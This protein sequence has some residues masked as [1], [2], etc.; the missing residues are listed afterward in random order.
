MSDI[1]WAPGLF[2]LTI[3]PESY[4]LDLTHRRLAD[5]VIAAHSLER[6]EVTLIEMNERD[7]V[8]S[9]ISRIHGRR[10]TKHYTIPGSTG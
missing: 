1:D 4:R 8:V 6:N 9:F 7:A 3:T 5:Q 10:W 2:T